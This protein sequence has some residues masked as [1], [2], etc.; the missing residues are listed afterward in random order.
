LHIQS[1]ATGSGQGF[2]GTLGWQFGGL[3]TVGM[4]FI[5]RQAAAHSQ[6]TPH[7]LVQPASQTLTPADVVP[8]QISSLLRSNTSNDPVNAGTTIQHTGNSGATVTITLEN[9]LHTVILHKQ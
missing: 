6:E 2:G 7:S 4:T 3:K 1:G 9:F 5:G 8:T